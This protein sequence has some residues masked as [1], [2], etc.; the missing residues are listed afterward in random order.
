MK[1]PGCAQATTTPLVSAEPGLRDGF[2]DAMSINATAVTV[3]TTD[4]AAGRKGVT[5]SAFTSVSADPPTVLVCTRRASPARDAIV[6]NGAFAVNLL[7]ED[8]TDISDIFSG[9]GASRF[10]FSAHTWRD[11]SLGLPVSPEAVAVFECTVAAAYESGSH[12]V[13]IGQ[14]R[15]VHRGEGQPLLYC[16]RR[17]TRLA[18]KMDQHT[19]AGVQA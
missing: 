17:Y 14:V 6:H 7:H 16:Q 11:G 5:V 15:E 1:E 10:D 4:G 2:I 13:I 9:R 18:A 8:Q 19:L 12:T 3:V